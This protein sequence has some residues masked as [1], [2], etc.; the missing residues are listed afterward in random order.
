[1]MMKHTGKKEQRIIEVKYYHCHCQNNLAMR[2][3]YD[4]GAPDQKF[5]FLNAIDEYGTQVL[6]I[7]ADNLIIQS[8]FYDT[9]HGSNTDQFYFSINGVMSQVVLD[10]D[11]NEIYL[12]IKRDI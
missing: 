9:S 8:S 5:Q 6:A 7:L 2:H 3:Q 1:M 10:K 11:T 12:F 4:L